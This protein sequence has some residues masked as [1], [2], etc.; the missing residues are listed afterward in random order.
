MELKIEKLLK[1]KG[2]KYRIIKL[3]Q[4]A[5]TVADV[6]KYSGGKV[7]TEEICKTIILMSKKNGKAA[8]LLLR[9]C[10]KLDFSAVKNLFGERLAIAS[11]DQVKKVTGV[12]PGAVCPLMLKA[13]LFVDQKVLALKNINCGSGHH[14]YGIEFQTKDL[15]K[16]VNYKT[17]NFAN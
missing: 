6:V 14:L 4:T 10:D 12:E 11:P 5:Y 8:A 3:S 15:I 17:A 16:G 7:K 13:P 1:A 9:G 2:I